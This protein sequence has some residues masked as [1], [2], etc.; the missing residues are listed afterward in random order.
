MLL[1]ALLASPGCKKPEDGLGLD[2]L[3]PDKALGTQVTDSTSIVAWTKVPDASRTSGLSR[4]VLGSYLDADFGRVSTGIVAQVRLSSNNVIFGTDVVCDSLILALAYDPTAYGYGSPDPQSFKVFR[5]SEDLSLDSVYKNDHVPAADLEDLLDGTRDQYTIDPTTRPYIDGDSLSP[6]LRLPLKRLLGQEILQLGSLTLSNS[7]EF[8]Q[9]FKGFMILPGDEPS[10]PFQRAAL[11]FN[12]L[13]ADSKLTLYYHHTG[14]G[15]SLKFDFNIN[16]SC[17]RYTLSSF[18]HGSALQPGLPLALQDSTEGQRHIYIQALN[19]LR[20]ELRFPFLDTYAAQG[21]KAVAKA[22]LIIPLEGSY[23]PTYVP[24]EQI[25]AFRKDASGKDAVL[26]D[27][28]N[29]SNQV[30]GL[31][32]ANTHEYRLVITQWVQKVINGDLP[33]TGLSIIPGASGVTVNRA[34]LAGPMNSTGPMK[35]RL[36]FTTY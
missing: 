19:G 4:N 3:D 35:L 27:Q 14:A 34:V 31:F 23:F 8:L 12:L 16:T 24:P 10:I 25:F 29:A 2:V 11:Y 21:L 13:N 30:G 7:T 32:D 36:T 28:V 6:Q 33:N 9:W 22:E 26:P 5:L 1:F 17:V 20:G 18:D 15:D